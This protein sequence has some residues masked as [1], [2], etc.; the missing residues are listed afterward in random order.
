MQIYVGS[1]K[2]IQEMYLYNDMDS[3]HA[4]Q[5]KVRFQNSTNIYDHPHPQYFIHCDT[6]NFSHVHTDVLVGYNQF[7]QNQC[8]LMSAND[9]GQSYV[10]GE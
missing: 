3:F 4:M 5:H 8:L 9:L 7:T 6:S 10:V 2:V 1:I